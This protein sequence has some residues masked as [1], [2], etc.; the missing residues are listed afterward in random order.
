[1]AEASPHALGRRADVQ[2]LRALAVMVVV[3]NHLSPDSLVGGWL[4]VDVFFVLSGYL[5][6][7]LLVREALETGRVS[8]TGFYARRARR[9]LPAATLV[10]VLTIVASVF[11]LSLSRTLSVVTDAVWTSL[12]AMNVRM[13]EQDSDYFSRG[14]PVSPLR[15]Y[16]SLAVEEQFYLVWPL[17]FVL[18]V[19]LALRTTRRGDGDG[20]RVEAR[21]LRL[22]AGLLLLVVVVAS[23]AWSVYATAAS[24]ETAYY[25]TFTRAHELAIGAACGLVPRALDLP[26]WLREAAAAGGLVVIVWACF[27]FVEGTAFPAANA[28][29]PS[30]ATAAVLLAGE[31]GQPALASRLLG[32]RP[33]TVL[34][35]WSFSIYLWHWPVIVLAAAWWGE[36]LTAAAKL[37]LLALTL[38]LSW[39]SYRWVENPFR[40]KAVWRRR[41]SRTLWIYPVSVATV[42]AIGLAASAVVETRMGGVEPIDAS[43]YVGLDEDPD[44]A[45][46]EAAV[47]AA[48]DGHGIPRKLTPEPLQVLRSVT[49]LGKCEYHENESTELCPMGDPDADSLVM[50]VGDSYARVLLSGVDEIGRR[51]GHRVIGLVHAGCGPGAWVHRA[52]SEDGRKCERFKAWMRSKVAEM[53]PDVVVVATREY[54]LEDPRTGERIGRTVGEDRYLAALEES[55]TE[56]FRDF[57]RDAGR[58]VVY[59]NT[60]QLSQLPQE[61]LT[62]PGNDLGSCT[63]P[64]L[65]QERRVAGALQRAAERADAT[66]VDAERWF[67]ADG[68]CPPVIGNFIAMR[69]LRHPTVEYTRH[70]AGPLA[71][72]FGL[73]RAGT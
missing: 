46:V 21:R 50:V 4:G 57:D 64:G 19:W 25:S 16:W 34:G 8:L 51:H 9:I 44:V 36:A 1:M 40:T 65:E 59:G 58:V 60:P 10:T 5:I 53:K 31:S 33:A 37:A 39:A 2:G 68:L 27:G 45:L 32:L 52:G 12:F 15:H 69:D 62:T 70:L 42:V 35:D 73:A 26:R 38:L 13:A 55:W 7:A 18:C 67:C 54:P 56:A 20:G 48:E 29:V 14:G 63:G 28:L 49:E 66:W 61:C 43:K 71:E 47:R 22:V 30:L 11:V 6:T 23:L 3:V 24:P 17:L 41:P 72:Q